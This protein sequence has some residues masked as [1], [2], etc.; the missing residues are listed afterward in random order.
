MSEKKK[1][2]AGMIL[3]VITVL[4]TAAGLF[5]YLNNC[6]TNYFSSIGTDQ[7]IVICLAASL[8][9]EILMLVLSVKIGAKPVLDLIPPVCGAMTAYAVIQFIGSRIAGAASIMTFENNTQ[10]MADLSGAITAMAVCAAALVC[11]MLTSFFKVVKE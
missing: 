10:N 1:I 4:V 9:L 7:N 5:L 2:G 3:G 6:K 8:V 11:V